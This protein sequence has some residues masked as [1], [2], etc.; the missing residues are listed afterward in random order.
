MEIIEKHSDIDWN[1]DVIA[2]SSPVLTLEMLNKFPDTKIDW[3]FMAYNRE[4]PIEIIEAYPNE[5]WDWYG[6]SWNKNLTINFIEKNIDEDWDWTNVSNNPF[7]IDY[8]I[9]LNKKLRFEHYHEE[10]IRKAW[11][12]NR[13]LLWCL[14]EEDKK[15]FYEEN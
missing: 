9:E 10:L 11:H 7:E 1:W 6:F 8:K 5:P 2:R 15:S 13:F 12:P 3:D 14:D 4:L